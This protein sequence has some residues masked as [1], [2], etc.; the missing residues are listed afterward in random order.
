MKRL[1]T[2]T[3]SI[4]PNVLLA[5]LVAAMVAIPAVGLLSPVP[6]TAESRKLNAPQDIRTPIVHYGNCQVTAAITDRNLDHGDKPEF[7]LTVRNSGDQEDRFEI[8]PTVTITPYTPA[9]RRILLMPKPVTCEPI[10]VFVKPQETVEQN[11][12]IDYEMIAGETVNLALPDPTQQLVAM[13]SVSIPLLDSP[14]DETPN[15]PI[16]EE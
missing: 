15:E 6:L 3:R 5:S 2:H 10:R 9:N 4:L 14:A 8:L 12:R 1:L 7:T 16:V 11:I 13:D